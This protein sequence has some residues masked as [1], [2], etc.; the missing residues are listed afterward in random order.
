MF[1]RSFRWYDVSWPGYGTGSGWG[2]RAGTMVAVGENQAYAAKHYEQGWYPTHTPGAGNRLG[3]GRLCPPEHFRGV[4]GQS[5][6]DGVQAVRQLRRPGPHRRRQLGHDGPDYRPCRCWSRP[7]GTA[8][9]WCSAPA[10]SRARPKRSGRSRYTTKVRASYSSTAVLT[11]DNSPRMTCRP[12]SPAPSRSALI[13]G[14][15]T[16]PLGTSQMAGAPD[17][18]GVSRLSGVVAGRGLLHVEQFQDRRRGAVRQQAGP[19]PRLRLEADGRVEGEVPEAV[20]RETLG[21]HPQR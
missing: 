17:S 10:S 7:M 18:P 12:E 2:A 19:Q 8:A 11:A 3:S 9:N 4:G 14:M 1:H 20:G 15:H 6:A 13:T 5:G 21:S 16:G